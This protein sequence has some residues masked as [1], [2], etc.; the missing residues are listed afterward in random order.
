MGTFIDLTQKKY[1]NKFGKWRVLHRDDQRPEPM[2]YWVCRCKCGNVQ[3]VNG[4]NLRNGT[5]T[6]CRRCADRSIEGAVPK[7]SPGDKVGKWTIL[8]RDKNATGYLCRCD[9]GYEGVRQIGN[10]GGGKTGG[11][12]SCWRERLAKKGR[13]KRK[14]LTGR[15]VWSAEQLALLGTDTDQAIAVRLGRTET[16]VTLKRTRLKI[17][18]FDQRERTG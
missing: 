6:Q 1:R 8:R 7:H 13:K 16:A 10:L 2:A 18:H 5:S 12:K 14:Q 3:T 17:P 15:T 4:K 9:C 11:C